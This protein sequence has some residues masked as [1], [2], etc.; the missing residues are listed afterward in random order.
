MPIYRIG[1]GKYLI[2]TESK[3]CL[4]KGNSCVVRVG[5]GFQTLEEYLE[6]N[7]ASEVEK[8]AKM[9]QDQNKTY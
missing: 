8:I 6:R 2:G 9:M 4:I 1:E 3:M 7:S 5:G